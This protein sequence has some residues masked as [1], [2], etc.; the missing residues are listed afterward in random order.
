MSCFTPASAL[1]PH[2]EE[3]SAPVETDCQEAW[4]D[5]TL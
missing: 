2:T 4:A 3:V 5:D 1:I